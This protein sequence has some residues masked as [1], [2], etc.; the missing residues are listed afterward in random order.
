MEPS[1][2]ST[3]QWIA[4][5]SPD[6][7]MKHFKAIS[8]LSVLAVISALSL[9]KNENHLSELEHFATDELFRRQLALSSVRSPIKASGQQCKDGPPTF[10]PRTK[11]E[12][13]YLRQVHEC[14]QFL[15]K[16][17]RW[18]PTFETNIPMLTCDEE[19]DT[20]NQ[21]EFFRST[22][23]NY[24]RIWFIGDS[25]LG[26][27]FNTLQC[28]LDPSSNLPLIDRYRFDHSTNS[29]SILDGGDYEGQPPS[30]DDLIESYPSST[31]FERITWGWKFERNDDT[32]FKTTFPTILREATSNDAIVINAGAHYNHNRMNL[33]GKALRF[34]AQKSSKTDASVFFV[35][36]TPEEWKTSNGMYGGKH[37]GCVKLTKEQ[38]LGQEAQ[39]DKKTKRRKLPPAT[40]RTDLARSI[41]AN[42]QKNNH[43]VNF[44]PTFWQLIASNQTSHCHEGDCT[45]KSLSAVYLMNLQ[46]MR[47]VMDNDHSLEQATTNNQRFLE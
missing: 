5:F 27:Q 26:Q 3:I 19:I 18:P 6:K 11:S 22:I 38:L 7:I 1:I 25:V 40:W 29:V 17:H 12:L 24:Q 2:G 4:L 13:D 28:M 39:P 32:L 41:F 37:N 36:P 14:T 34:I 10:R 33:M 16:P 15:E 44:V 20:L 35:E 23:K 30:P 9:W 43:K 47:A 45:H 42:S 31:T 46:L 21:L 8:S